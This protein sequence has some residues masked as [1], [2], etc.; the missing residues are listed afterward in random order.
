[1]ENL[2]FIKNVSI[3]AE[4]EEKEIIKLV[5]IIQEIEFK[6]DDCIF[7]QGDTGDALYVIK[8]GTVEIIK[9]GIS[10]CNLEIGAFFGEMALVESKPRNAKI[11]AIDDVLLLKISKKDFNF[12]IRSNPTILLKIV[13]FMTER[14]R[15]L[16]RAED[17]SDSDKT[18]TDKKKEATIITFFSAKG[19]VGKSL[20]IS[21]MSSLMAEI[22]K[23]NGKKILLWDMDFEFGC[24]DIL[25]NIKHKATIYEFVES[26]MEDWTFEDL[27]PFLYS[28]DE[29][30]NLSVFI[31]PDSPEKSEVVNMQHVR[32]LLFCF[33][34]HFDYIF[35]D[36]PSS[37][38][39]TTITAL[40]NSDH[41]IF[42]LT[43]EIPTIRN[44]IRCLKLMKSLRYP[45]GTVKLLINNFGSTLDIETE[46]IEQ[47]L[48]NKVIAT[49][50]DEKEL[51]MDAV[52]KGT[53][54][55]KINS[56]SSMVKTMKSIIL[57]VAADDDKETIKKSANVSDSSGGFMSKLKKMFSS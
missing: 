1:M 15:V 3:F 44:S 28:S 36:L 35:I 39:D 7:K 14:A 34:E 46:K 12:F 17:G 42:T 37:F 55:H 21:N 8:K 52:I 4:L 22:L 48:E 19:G 2:E 32:N 47:K 43:K 10:V 50:A 51:V 29:L 41:I 49:M 16:A 40:D 56:S 54:V 33:K 24:V 38:L 30:E 26:N 13:S 9:N 45:A 11:T 5:E 57:K 53:L 31:S 23:E 18:D 25:L 27:K 20:I 6:K